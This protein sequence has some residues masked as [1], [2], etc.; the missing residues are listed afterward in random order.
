MK[1]SRLRWA[2]A[3][4]ATT[5]TATEKMAKSTGNNILPAELFSGKNTVLSKAFSPGVAKFFMY[6]GQYR[7]ILDFSNDALV[8][9]EKGYNKLMDAYKSIGDISHSERSSI[10]ITTWRQSCS[11]QP[12]LKGL[13]R[14]ACPVIPSGHPGVKGFPRGSRL[15]RN[16]GVRFARL[17]KIRG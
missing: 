5:T 6:Q 13:M 7:S 3:A 12:Q 14:C 4:T 17:P 1:G 16:L 11:A 2:T 10:D 15:T 8:A 9:S